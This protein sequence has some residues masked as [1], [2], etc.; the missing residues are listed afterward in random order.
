[1]QS[2]ARF[3]KIGFE[4]SLA[5]CVVKPGKC[6]GCGACVI[7]CPFKSLEYAN[8]NPTLIMGCKA[9]GICVAVCPQYE[10]SLA[11][12]EKFVFDRE[13]SAEEESGVCRKFILAQATDSK[14]RAISQDGGVVTALLS[15]ALEKGLIDGAIVS[16]VDKERPFL[17]VPK[18]A[19][20]LEE[21]LASAGTKYSYSPNILALTEAVKQKKNIAFVGTP[22]QI[23]AVRRMHVAGLRYASPVKFLIGLMCSECFLYEG[24]MGKHVREALG[25]DLGSIRKM[26][27]KGKMLIT[28]ESG[29]QTIS[30]AEA[31][32]YARAN[33]GFCNDFSSELADISAGG[34]GLDGWTFTIVRTEKGEQLFARAEKEGSIK[35]RNATEEANALNLLSKLSRKKRQN[36]TA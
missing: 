11:E 36:S 17:P 10:V 9:C 18:L 29:V 8:G 34:L 2:T 31:K 35:T 25:I 32:Q 26:N 13:R 30:L 22:C 3:K 24:L 19:T 20:T 16:G 4:E 7:V 12:L 28:T 23:R 14:I 5:T 1:M 15:F 6:L 33:C 27:I 21:I